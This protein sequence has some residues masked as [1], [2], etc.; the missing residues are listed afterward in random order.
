MS[1]VAEPMPMFAEG[2]V[3]FDSPARGAPHL[4]GGYC[5]QCDRWSFPRTEHCRHCHGKSERRSLGSYGT[6]YSCTVVRTKPPLK[7]PQPYAVAYVDLRDRPLRIFML[8]DPAAADS[9]QIGDHVELVVGQV[10]VNREG[11]ACLRPYFRPLKAR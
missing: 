10:G 6:V 5:R 1:T 8:I 4:I 2:V 3:G 7:F 9:V 11:A